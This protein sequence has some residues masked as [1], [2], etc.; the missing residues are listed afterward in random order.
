MAESSTTV[1]GIAILIA[2]GGWASCQLHA[3][4]R[5]IPTP[6]QLMKL[7]LALKGVPG[8]GLAELGTLYIYKLVLV[9]LDMK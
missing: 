9:E 4:I 1:I 3:S 2:G 6:S 7:L 5:Y 8:R